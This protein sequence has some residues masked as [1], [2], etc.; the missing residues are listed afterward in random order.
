MVW[1][2]ACLD[3][4]QSSYATDPSASWNDL[5][6]L[7]LFPLQHIAM[8]QLGWGHSSFSHQT[9]HMP[10]TIHRYYTRLPFHPQQIKHRKSWWIKNK[11][12]ISW[13]TQMVYPEFFS[14]PL[15]HHDD[16]IPT[17]KRNVR[18]V[19]EC[20]GSFAP[21]MQV[22]EWHLQKI[23]WMFGPTHCFYNL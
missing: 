9:Q 20:G 18:S 12:Q 4:T 19:Q 23:I 13:K 1:K 5:F 11:I 14:S 15:S 17:Q 2:R 22:H 7:E 10:Y 3:E 6:M 21:E 8:I 16:P